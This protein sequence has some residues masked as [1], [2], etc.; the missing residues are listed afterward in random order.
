MNTACVSYHTLDVSI[1]AIIIILILA[2]FEINKIPHKGGIYSDDM[3]MKRHF[4]QNLKL[5]IAFS[6][7]AF[8]L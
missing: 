8:I 6:I 1:V 7:S 5:E 4:F 3:I 2:I